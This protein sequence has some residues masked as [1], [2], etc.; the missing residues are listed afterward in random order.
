VTRRGWCVLGLGVVVYAAAWAFGSKPLYPVAAGLLFVS[1]LAWLWVRIGGRTFRLQ[2]RTG[3]RDLFEGDDAVVRLKLEPFG[4]PPLAAI[5]IVERIRGLGE[6]RHALRR[7]GGA[8]RIDYALPRLRRGRYAY[9]EVRAELGDPFGLQRVKVELP[10]PGALLVYP[11][12]VPLARVFSDAGS[13]GLDGRRILLRRPAGFELH[14]VREHV[15]GESLRRVHWPSTARRARLMVRELE[16]APRDEIAVLLD[17]DARA[18]VGESFDVQVR[19][20]ASILSAHVDR[21]RRA[22]LTVNSARA[23]ATRVHSDASDWRRALDLLASV[24]P[25]GQTSLTTF[26]RADAGVALR[27]VELTLVTARLEPELVGQLLQRALSRRRVAVVY[28]DAATFAAR[29]ARREPELLRLS[30]AGVPVAVVRAGDDLRRSLEGHVP[31]EVA[32]A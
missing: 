6:Q 13:Q 22:V 26:L 19:A 20:A 16:D 25:D 21:G 5:E 24:Q 15:E 28:V 9:D 31:A 30:A 2:R 18:V 17:A 32:R 14:S 3:E 4:R 12:I 1:A 23:S 29:P 8:L 10:A 7:F 27:A 11:R